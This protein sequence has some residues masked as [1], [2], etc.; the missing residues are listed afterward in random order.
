MEEFSKNEKILKL[1]KKF[2]SFDKEQ[3]KEVKETI[4]NDADF[5]DYCLNKTDW[6]YE[7]HDALIEI[8]EPIKNEGHYQD[9]YGS[10]VSYNGIKTLKKANT[11]LIMSK[12]HSNE[13]DKCLNDF[14]YFRKYYCK[15]QTKNGIQRP[16]PRDY[17]DRLEDTLISLNDT[18]V[19]FSRQS[20]KCVLFNTSIS[21]KNKQTNQ[22]ERIQIGEFY[23]RIEKQQNP[24]LFSRLVNYIQKAL[25]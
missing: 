7:E 1:A 25:S 14:K 19:S 11:E 2:S 13:I 15:I 16:E 9:T 18:A 21:I 12:I 22:I 23:K 6:T 20:G 4:Q 17:Q 10:K 24:S 3:L 5:I 8:L